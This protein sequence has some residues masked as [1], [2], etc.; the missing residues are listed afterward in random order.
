MIKRLIKLGV[1]LLI[2]LGKSLSVVLG[3]IVSLIIDLQVL[4]CFK[5]KRVTKV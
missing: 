2:F 5:K 3:W 4:A 1:V